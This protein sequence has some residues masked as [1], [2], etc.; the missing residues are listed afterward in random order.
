MLM[1]DFE[2]QPECF[3]SHNNIKKKSGGFAMCCCY[4]LFFMRHNTTPLAFK[5]KKKHGHERFHD[6]HPER[7][8]S[9]KKDLARKNIQ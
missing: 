8:S 2:T 5:K 1:R 4:W 6:S 7:L 3:T 9:H